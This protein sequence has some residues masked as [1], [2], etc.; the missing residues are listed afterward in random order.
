M[1]RI[2]PLHGKKSLLPGDRIRFS[3]V[4]AHN[5][6]YLKEV[7]PSRWLTI[8]S[9]DAGKTFSVRH[10]P[11]MLFRVVEVNQSFYEDMITDWQFKQDLPVYKKPLTKNL[12]NI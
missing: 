11:I 5:L 4:C 7:S 12:P 3:N 10:S 6:P 2:K 9:V 8:K 1:Q